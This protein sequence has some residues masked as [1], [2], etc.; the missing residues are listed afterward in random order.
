LGG[1]REGKVK[2]IRN[3]FAIFLVS[4]LWHGANWTFIIWGCY[5]ALL[6]VPLL[7]MGKTKKYGEYNCEETFN[8][9]W[10][11]PVLGTFLL[12][13]I[14]WVI[15]RAD[16]I[17]QACIYLYGMIG[18]HSSPLSNCGLSSIIVL[19]ALVGVLFLIWMEFRR[20]GNDV[21][22]QF[23]SRYSAVN[24]IGY[25]TVAYWALFFYKEGQE[26]IYFQF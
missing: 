26:F 22:L 25:L 13:V 16:N 1:S 19:E 7:L 18:Y 9:N 4:G 10:L 17:H 11:L 14:G 24:W 21:V 8:L 6:F 5:H 12:A 23:H 3:T 15:F 2:T 20:R